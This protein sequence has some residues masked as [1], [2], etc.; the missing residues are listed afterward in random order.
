MKDLK[1]SELRM[2]NYVNYDVM[3]SVY[4]VRGIGK[5]CLWLNGTEFGGP[6]GIDLFS[7]I[8]LNEEWLVKLGFVRDGS[9]WSHPY[10]NLAIHKTIHEEE[11]IM[12]PNRRF[13]LDLKYV[14]QLQNLYFAL[15]GE[16]LEIQ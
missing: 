2:G 14:H 5:D 1:V 15:T 16:E 4:K 11:V 10:L 6:G 9:Y 8:P 7:P 13:A 3:E 12:I